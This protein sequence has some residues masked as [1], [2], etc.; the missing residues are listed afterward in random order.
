MHEQCTDPS[1]ACSLQT[2]VLL[3][4]GRR[5][6]SS[7]RRLQRGFAV[8][9][10]IPFAASVTVNAVRAV[11]TAVLREVEKLLFRLIK[12]PPPSKSPPPL[13]RQFLA[14]TSLYTLQAP[15]HTLSPFYASTIRCVSKTLV[16]VFNVGLLTD[17]LHSIVASAPCVSSM[18]ILQNVQATVFLLCFIQIS[19]NYVAQ[20]P[21]QKR[22]KDS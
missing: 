22:L 9:G 20:N 1:K 8:K 6:P 14:Q 4:L 5:G 17:A 15:M 18:S 12:R 21:R 11:A 19:P 10:A 7:L 2:S 16:L 13:W 3:R